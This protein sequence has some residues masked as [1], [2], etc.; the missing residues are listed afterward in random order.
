MSTKTLSLC[1]LLLFACGALFPIG[2][3]VSSEDDPAP[4]AEVSAPDENTDSEVFTDEV[5]ADDETSVSNQEELAKVL[6]EAE[7]ALANEAETE[8]AA[9]AEVADSTEIPDT[10]HLH[11]KWIHDA[12]VDGPETYEHHHEYLAKSKNKARLVLTNNGQ[13][14]LPAKGWALYF[15][16]GPFMYLDEEAFAQDNETVKAS[17]TGIQGRY[18]IEPTDGFKPLKADESLTIPIVGMRQIMLNSDPPVGFYLVSIDE[19]GNEALVGD[20]AIEYGP[21]KGFTPSPEPIGARADA[22]SRYARHSQY[23]GESE[24]QVAL[25][26]PRN[27]DLDDSK[28]IDLAQLAAVE[29]SDDLKFESDA[30][31][32]LL[33]KHRQA[34]ESDEAA[35]VS[36]TIDPELAKEQYKLTVNDEGVSLS[37]GSAAGVFYGIQTIDQLLDRFGDHLPYLTIDDQPQFSYRGLMVDICRHYFGPETLKKVIDQM[38]HYKMNIL[39]L[40]L[41]E[42]EA[43]RIEIP[44]LPELTEIGSKRGHVTHDADGK[45]V[46]LP[47]VLNDGGT[48]PSGYLTREDYIDLLKYAKARHIEVIPEIAVPGHARSAIQALLDKPGYLMIDPEDKSEHL[49]PQGFDDNILNPA[50][51]GVYPFLEEVFTAVNEMHDAAGVPLAHVHIGGD[52]APEEAWTLSPAIAAMGYE[53]VDP[54]VDPEK[55]V[56]V[57]RKI[58]DDFSQKLYEIIDNTSSGT[59]HVG[60][61]HENA[62]F[63]TARMADGKAYITEWDFDG[64]ATYARLKTGQPT[65]L[66]NPR[67]SYFDMAYENNPTERGH[68]W[69]GFTD[70][71]DVYEY[72]PLALTDK[73]LPQK[74]RDLIL[75]IQ[76]QLWTETINTPEMLEWYMLP[77]LLPFAERAWNPDVSDEDVADQWPAF[78]AFVGNYAL[79]R[80]EREGVHFRIPKPGAIEEDGKLKAIVP[81]PGLEIRYTTDGSEPVV[82]SPLYDPQDPPAYDAKIKLRAFTPE[83]RGSSTVPVE[84]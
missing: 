55:S 34:N 8:E 80:L 7:T 46:Q 12:N 54:K 71:K 56:A 27:V 4:E 29:S 73:P 75:G 19:D 13:T 21:I 3:T 39:Q 18:K 23:N 68:F 78:A 66:C 38:A 81:Y 50:M 63:V 30:L 51:E 6:D 1:T 67:T 60:S 24:P 83:G 43:W 16:I 9:D 15:R 49:S 84:E 42:D 41:N 11:L 77:R 82:E 74:E 70:T 22:K 37:G 36:L 40:R 44:S 45:V 59:V 76:S 35:T 79:P 25:P 48:G 47:V 10:S 33:D 32:T 57:H 61:W 52:E 2:C 64:D 69:S 26:A 17:F 5:P 62:P 14:A 58:R 53:N 72:R 20:I 31:T 28:K 65:V